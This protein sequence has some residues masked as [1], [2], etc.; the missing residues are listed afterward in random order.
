[1]AC[2]TARSSA[3]PLNRHG[4]F[5]HDRGTSVHDRQRQQ[6]RRGSSLAV[7]EIWAVDDQDVRDV[8]YV[9]VWRT[10]PRNWQERQGDGR[11]TIW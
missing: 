3:R 10:R 2:W 5:G 9:G 11:G 6:D 1:M 4:S 8:E 7:Q